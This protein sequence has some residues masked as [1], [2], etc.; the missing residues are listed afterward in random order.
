MDFE[1]G[2]EE[3]QVRGA[4]FA[5]FCDERIAARS[6]RGERI[7]A[8]LDALTSHRAAARC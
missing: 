8:L 6:L 7:E 4:T 5:R 2:E 1:P 3:R